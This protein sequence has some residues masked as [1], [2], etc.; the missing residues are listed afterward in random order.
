MTSTSTS[1]STSTQGTELYR[2]CLPECA[3]SIESHPS[4]GGLFALAT[5]QVDQE[6]IARE[7]GSSAGTTTT[8]SS[9]PY[10]RKGQV[11]LYQYDYGAQK[12]TLTWQS[13]SMAAVLDTKWT[14]DG[15]T[16]GV[17][18]AMGCV[19]L[20]R[21]GERG[22]A[23]MDAESTSTSTLRMNAK[24][25]L[26]LSLD[27][28]GRV[29]HT[30][31]QRL[32]VSQSDGSLAFVPSLEAARCGDEGG[33]AVAWSGLRGDG[34]EDSEQKDDDSDDADDDD[35]DEAPHA[36]SSP[37]HATPPGL[38]TWRAHGHE[39]WIAAFDPFSHGRLIWS[40]GDDL[41]LKGWDVRTR[42]HSHTRQAT[43]TNTRSFTTG[44]V[45]TMEAHHSR[46]GLW[47]VGSYDGHLR[48]FDSRNPLRPVQD[49]LELPGGIWRLKW[50]PTDPQRLL[51]ACMHGGFC[52]VQVQQEA[53][54]VRQFD[55]HDSLAYGCDWDRGVGEHE[56][57]VYSCSFYDR[58]LCAWRA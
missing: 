38:E 3:D 15:N 19:S 24:R 8:T 40:G 28:S 42:L 11:R 27:F 33:A 30:Q 13:P 50:H 58:R 29:I 22:K 43:F 20:L 57:N 47:A 32:V 48:L 46:E 26:C 14:R 17:A 31:D 2:E 5:Y 9:P 7:M 1:T 49:P 37:T 41:A 25:A 16:L 4:T 45:T 56:N 51:A 23:G 34:G 18:D 12:C 52:V 10:T 35:R 36:T 6:E 53:E 39:A 54:I 21:V 44:G 55:G